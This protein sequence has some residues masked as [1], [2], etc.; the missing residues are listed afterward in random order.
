[1]AVDV[2]IGFDSLALVLAIGLLLARGVLVPAAGFRTEELVRILRAGISL[3]WLCL[4]VLWLTSLAWLWTRTAAMSGQPLWAALP[5]VPKVLFRSHFGA[6]WWLRAA[7]LLWSTLALVVITRRGGRVGWPG[8]G[9]LLFGLAWVGASRSAAGHA[10]AEG[11]WTLREAMDWLH[12]MVVSVWGGSLLASLLLIFPWLGSVP[13]ARQARFGARF[14][15]LASCALAVVLI[16]GIYNAWQMLPSVSALWAS[17][18]G[19]LL[20]LKLLFVAG[21][22]AC[23]AINHYQLVPRLQPAAD[24]DNSD[25][26]RRFR[27]SVLVESALLLAVL[28]VTAVLL[29]TMPPMA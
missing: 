20:G 27:A 23:G 25:V 19:R 26:V 3:C 9:L 16:S 4:A 17:Q 24:A 22:V 12:L 6:V 13:A 1:M 18:Y 28:A 5:V 8:I 21:M 2:V 14:S 10:A 29:N 11:D 15:L 7:A